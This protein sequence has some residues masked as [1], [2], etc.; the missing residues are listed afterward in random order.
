M[1][2]L[3]SARDKQDIIMG[4]AAEMEDGNYWF[5]EVPNGKYDVKVT[6]KLVDNAV[7][8]KKYTDK[9]PMDFKINEVE[10]QTP[11]MGL[12]DEII[13]DKPNIVVKSNE[14]R[15]TW[16]KGVVSIVSVFVIPQEPEKDHG[17]VKKTVAPNTFK[18]GDCLKENTK[19][20]VFDESLLTKVKCDGVMVKISSKASNKD[21][22]CMYKCVDAKFDN[23]EDCN[24][25]LP[26][27][28]KCLKKDVN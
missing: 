26:E 23:I 9:V 14:I 28:L 19:N 16:V 3:A 1:D 5:I 6:L 12:K 8:Q 11:P 10:V 25:N 27:T 7:N 15:L 24:K 17:A 20:C 18:G 4:T 22:A 21:I 2:D 13:H